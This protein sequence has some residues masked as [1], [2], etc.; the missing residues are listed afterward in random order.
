MECETLYLLLDVD[1]FITS[2]Q[3]TYAILEGER[4]DTRTTSQVLRSAF[5]PD[6][7]CLQAH[8]LNITVAIRSFSPLLL[9]A[10]RKG[11]GQGQGQGKR[12]REREWEKGK[13]RGAIPITFTTQRLL[14]MCV[15]KCSTFP[16]KNPLKGVLGMPGKK[17]IL[18]SD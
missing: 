5:Y 16:L 15:C 4:N 18:K 10:M 2:S 1:P 14:E 13:K 6:P 17:Y 3:Q 8:G 7:V 12:G 11:E 9:L